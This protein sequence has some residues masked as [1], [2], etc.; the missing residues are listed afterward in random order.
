MDSPNPDDLGN[1]AFYDSCPL[2][3]NIATLDNILNGDFLQ[4]MEIT[5]SHTPKI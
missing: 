2:V 5:Q 1:T 4:E 3:E